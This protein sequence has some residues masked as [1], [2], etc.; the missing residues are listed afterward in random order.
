MKTRFL[1]GIYLPVATAV[2]GVAGA[3]ATTSMGSRDVVDQRGYFRDSQE[4][5]QE[6]IMCQTEN[7]NVIC[8]DGSHELWGKATPN[9]D[10]DIRLYQKLTP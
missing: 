3:F 10:C 2:L 1:K 9:A 4:V 5:C 6:S 8:S 7:N